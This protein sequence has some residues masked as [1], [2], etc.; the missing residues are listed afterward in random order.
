MVQKRGALSAQTAAR[1]L[2]VNYRTVVAMLK[3]GELRGNS[4]T[5]RH[6]TT[7]SL[8][9]YIR[10]HATQALATLTDSKE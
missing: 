2:R 8:R 3:R 4:T 9:A 7:L 5:P 6:V 10:R 1:M